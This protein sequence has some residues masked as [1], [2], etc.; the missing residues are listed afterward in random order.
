MLEKLV[1]FE[2]HVGLRNTAMRSDCAQVSGRKFLQE[3]DDSCRMSINSQH[4]QMG[5]S[6]TTGYIFIKYSPRWKVQFN[7]LGQ[8]GQSHHNLS[9][10]RTGASI[11]DIPDVQGTEVDKFANM[12]ELTHIGYGTYSQVL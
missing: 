8:L 5:E 3:L 6:T 10:G 7:E 11:S 9:N 12:H 2:I 1:G 4:L